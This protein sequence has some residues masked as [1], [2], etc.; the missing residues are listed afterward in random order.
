MIL[1]IRNLQIGKSVETENKLLVA[2]DWD[3]GG[4]EIE[5][6]YWQAGGFFFGWWIC[7]GVG[8]QRWLHKFVN[9][10]KTTELYTLKGYTVWFG[11]CISVK[12]LIKTFME[13]VTRK[14]KV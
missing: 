6:D 5:S 3:S 14:K 10:C 11:N 4:Q 8:T 2:K 13:Q 9:I 7:S 12:L 1:L